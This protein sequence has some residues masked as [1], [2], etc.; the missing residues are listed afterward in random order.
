[1]RRSLGIVLLLAVILS[2]CTGVDLE[3]DKQ[4]KLD[5]IYLASTG[6]LIHFQVGQFIADELKALGSIDAGI[7]YDVPKTRLE[8]DIYAFFQVPSGQVLHIYELKPRHWFDRLGKAAQAQG[9]IDKYRDKL[10]LA[11][12][13]KNIPIVRGERWYAPPKGRAVPDRYVPEAARRCLQ[14]MVET[15]YED[16]PG[17]IW[18]WYRWHPEKKS[19][20][21]TSCGNQTKKEKNASLSGFV[22]D[23]ADSLRYKYGQNWTARSQEKAA[24]VAYTDDIASMRQ[25]VVD[26]YY[27]DDETD[28]WEIESETTRAELHRQ[29]M[30][31]YIPS[32]FF[33]GQGWEYQSYP[34]PGWGNKHKTPMDHWEC[35]KEAC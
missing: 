34:M 18:Y 32:W 31:K 33:S 4:W 8:V 35:T 20:N 14:V 26:V 3:P 25:Q 10:K 13:L 15:R 17:L 22:W 19:V 24:M 6:T 27:Y 30:P 11:A 23:A 2:G 1:M 5:D 7:N 9:Q 16:S 29:L 12:H 21:G 28:D